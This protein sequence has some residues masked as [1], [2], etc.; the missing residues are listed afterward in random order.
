M[1]KISR[2]LVFNYIS[3]WGDYT[4]EREQDKQALYGVF[5]IRLKFLVFLAFLKFKLV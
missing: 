1:N 5:L 3:K 4:K 2:L